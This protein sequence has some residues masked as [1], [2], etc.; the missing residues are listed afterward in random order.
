M[1]I[2]L[3]YLWV[4][5]ADEKWRAKKDAA[6]RRL[7]RA[8]PAHSKAGR[9][10]DDGGEL[11]FSLR[12]VARFAPW[13]NH[14]YIIT[15]GQRPKW[16]ATNPRVSVIDHKNIIPKELLPTFNS[17]MI[18]FFIHKIPGLSEH[19]LYSNDDM[20][21]GRPATPDMFFDD[22]GRP[23]VLMGR[24]G[25]RD[26]GIFSDTCE[27][28]LRYAGAAGW[29]F[30]HAI[31]PMRKSDMEAVID[32]DYETFRRTTFTPFRERTNIQRMVIGLANRA[33]GRGIIRECRRDDCKNIWSLGW[34]MMTGMPRTFCINGTTPLN[35][36]RRNL[37]A[38]RRLFP[39]KSEFEK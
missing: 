16:L 1:K 11:K 19:F 7:G 4:D 12:S 34:N 39:D 15:D 29:R 13:I 36:F 28:A 6:L 24:G 20:F 18:E 17:N 25:A 27:N 9:L 3:V 31:E 38:M 26:R 22:A 23:I 21:F 8:V 35:S 2:D 37:P 5:G 30:K 33:G 14:I 32:A 10:F